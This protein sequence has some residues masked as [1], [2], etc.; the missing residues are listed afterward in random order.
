MPTENTKH[1][2]PPHYRGCLSASEFERLRPRSAMPDDV[3]QTVRQVLVDAQ[4][5][6]AV[7]KASGL[8]GYQLYLRT[9][10]FMRTVQQEP[11]L[12]DPDA[13]EA[14]LIDA[15]ERHPE[16]TDQQAAFARAVKLQGWHPIHARRVLGISHEASR[17]VLRWLHGDAAQR[18]NYPRFAAPEFEHLTRFTNT[19][20]ETLAVVRAVL[21]D[22]LNCQQAGK[23]A[24]VTRQA[25]HTDVRTFLK[26]LE[27][28]K[29]KTPPVSLEQF[30][31]RCAQHGITG[32][33]RDFLYHLVMEGCSRKSARMLAGL[34]ENRA[35]TMRKKFFRNRE[36]LPK[37]RPK[38]T[39]STL[40][41][42]GA[43]AAGCG[44]MPA[45]G[46]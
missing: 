30:Q 24:G 7:A 32:A 11:V 14:A 19:R 10:R 20:P 3:L 2:T 26:G 29:Q 44:C 34:S 9:M 46:L 22:G 1:Q 28:T 37:G 42:P 12:M 6:V 31:E 15:R 13:F 18:E 5:P 39:A 33:D 38:S 17:R 45:P 4:T 21:V 36:D 23:L 16:L 40:S 43:G 41:T 35:S 25:A 27:K 8:P